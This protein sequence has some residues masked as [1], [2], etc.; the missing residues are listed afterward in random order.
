MNLVSL[1]ES[2][3]L[4]VDEVVINGRRHQ[5]VLQVHRAQV[6]QKLRVGLIGKNLGWGEVT[7]LTTNQVRLRVE[8]K[9]P[10]PQAAPVRLVL[11]LPRPKNLARILQTVTTLGIKKIA[12]INS[13][14]VDKSFWSS[15]WLSPTSMRKACVL[16]LE[17]AIDTVLP[18]I[19]LFPA[20]KPFVED[21]VREWASGTECYVA[22]PWVKDEHKVSRQEVVTL[23]IGPE[24]GFVPYEFEKFKEQGFLPLRLGHR[25]LKV[26]AAIV[27]LTAPHLI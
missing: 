2:D 12:L 22:D 1:E 15:E 7:E 14:K 25:V 5:H 8:L 13:W 16:G 24:G 3:F 11:A 18:E 4:G 20:F 10:P 27:A 23:A 17:Q 6:G 19:D 9:E 21:S 26:E